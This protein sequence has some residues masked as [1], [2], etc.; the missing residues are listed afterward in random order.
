M[1][2]QVLK[3]K[4]GYGAWLFLTIVLLGYVVTAVLDQNLAAR[5]WQLFCQLLPK[6]L[7]ALL[8]VAVLLLLISLLLTPKQ[9]RGYLGYHS[10]LKGWLAA[11]LVGVFSSGPIYAWFAILHDLREKGMRDSLVAVMLYARAVKLPLL[12]LL[13]HYFGLTY[14]VILVL[15]LLSF[16]IVSGVIMERIG[17]TPDE[18][19]LRK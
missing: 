1:A 6:V 15:Y 4:T 11:L 9:V 7:P 14:A 10:G 3:K 17:L 2:E 8:F 12:P 13:I 19:K 16:A 5:A 18:Q